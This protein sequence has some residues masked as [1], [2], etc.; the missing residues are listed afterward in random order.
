M[1]W[2]SPFCTQGTHMP[3]LGSFVTSQNFISGMGIWRLV[4]LYLLSMGR[5]IV[6]DHS[7]SKDRLFRETRFCLPR[8]PWCIH[9][10]PAHCAFLVIRFLDD[11]KLPMILQ[12]PYTPDVAPPDFLLFSRLKTPM[13]GHH[14]GTLDNVKKAC[15]K[16]KGHR[17][18]YITLLEGGVSAQPTGTWFLDPL[19]LSPT[20]VL[21]SSHALSF[22]VTVQ[23]VTPPLSRIGSRCLRLGVQTM[24]CFDTRNRQ[25]VPKL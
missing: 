20:P 18:Y 2:A 17:S 21:P 12:L 10:T 15:T 25:A 11:S 6:S 14:F 7:E 9:K 16:T 3:S 13:K 24:L 22:L 4:S 1:Y 8:K 23:D 19:Y 5:S